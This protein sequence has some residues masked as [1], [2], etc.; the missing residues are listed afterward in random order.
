[1]K[2]KFLI[3]TLILLLMPMSSYAQENGYV[4][5]FKTDGEISLM[6]GGN[7]LPEYVLLSEEELK[8]AV[9][10]G[11][12]LSYEPNY[13]VYLFSSNYGLD[14]IC[15]YVPQKLGFDGSGV[16]V[17]VI[18]SG[19]APIPELK[20]KTMAGYNFVSNNLV[21]YDTLGHGTF[22]AS[23]IASESYGVAPGVK[24]I[25]LKAFDGKEGDLFDVLNALKKGV[26]EYNLDV[27]NMSLGTAE[28]EFLR[29]S[30]NA[31]L[32]K[33]IIVV[34]ASGNITKNDDGTDNNDIMY[35]AA[36]DGVIGVGAVDKYKN[37]AYFSRHNKGTDFTAPGVEVDGF[38]IK[39]NP[40]YGSGTS[41]AAPYVSGIAAIAKAID[42]NITPKE[43]YNVLKQTS[44]DLGNAG[45][46]EYY[47]HG[48][49]NAERVFKYLTQN[50]GII[51]KSYENNTFYVYNSGET[52][53][54]LIFAHRYLNTDR[55]LSEFGFKDG[56]T[57]K[58][59]TLFEYS[60]PVSE[61]SLKVMI[62]NQNLA[63][64]TQ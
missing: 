8:K 35:P 21:T 16:R 11:K 22:S 62:W 42:K 53:N 61:G 64:L 37:T 2:I 55:T 15:P 25:P 38:D 17:G 60:V 26:E 49:V 41:Y 29:D 27:I 18:D 13:P 58:K 6:S 34:A 4:A 3:L 51:V 36:Y 31:A 20:N 45:Y 54:N 24:L 57:L 1:M 14:M 59:Q 33:G 30:I 56:M 19:I 9:K 28:S 7:T 46:D 10:D 44:E 32:A 52:L 47:G 39:G 48:L 63:P 40:A 5:V 12:I 23:V 50:S 43:F